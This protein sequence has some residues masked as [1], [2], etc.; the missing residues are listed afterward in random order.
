MAR[1]YD[2]SE[3]VRTISGWPTI[4]RAN[5]EIA[6]KKKKKTEE[7]KRGFRE[8]SSLPIFKVGHSSFLSVSFK[9]STSSR[10]WKSPRAA[11]SFRQYRQ[12]VG[13]ERREREIIFVILCKICYETKRSRNSFPLNFPREMYPEPYKT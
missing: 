6:K 9:F 1:R 5:P 13:A 10:T 11:S 4:A 12:V 8:S 7:G 3:L 2:L